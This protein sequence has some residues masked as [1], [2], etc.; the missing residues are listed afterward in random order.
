VLVLLRN[1]WEI[2]LA[3]VIGDRGSQVNKRSDFCHIRKAH[4]AF[5]RGMPT[6]LFRTLSRLE[7]TQRRAIASLV[8][9]MRAALV[10]L[11]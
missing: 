3:H 10:M 8:L 11:N 5:A 2:Q 1:T 9:V 6:A 7:V 4:Q